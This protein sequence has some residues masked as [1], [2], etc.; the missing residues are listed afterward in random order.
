MAE[1][2]SV[3]EV[4][5]LVVVEALLTEEAVEDL[6]ALLEE[7]LAIDLVVV[8]DMV[9]LVAAAPDFQVAVVAHQDLEIDT[10]GVLLGHITIVTEVA[11]RLDKVP[12]GIK[13]NINSK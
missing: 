8:V 11:H 6:K 7:D 4:V 13:Y 3:V 5:H 10:M 9:H 2:V 1:A 12:R